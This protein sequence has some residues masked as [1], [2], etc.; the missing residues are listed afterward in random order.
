MYKEFFSQT[1]DG[2]LNLPIFT[3]ILFAIIFASVV[4]WVWRRGPNDPEHTRLA[5]LPL[6]NLEGEST[7]LHTAAAGGD[8]G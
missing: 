3:M 1:G 4:V 5:N 8:H 2:L 7:N 6:E